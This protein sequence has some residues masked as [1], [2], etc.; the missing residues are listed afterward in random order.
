MQKLLFLGGSGFLG[1][2]LIRHFSDGYRTFAV[3]RSAQGVS[4][5]QAASNTI[6][7]V[8][9]EEAAEI[10][11][12][13]IFNLIVDYGRGGAP[14]ARVMQSNLVHPLQMLEVIEA[15]AVIN[16]STALPPIYS[17]Y[18]L[19]K[20]LLEQSLVHLEE[21]KRRSFFNIH[22]HNM[23]GPG[24]EV[25]ELIGFAGSKLLTDQ[26]VEVSEC[27]NSRDFIFV[28]DVV[29]ALSTISKNTD[30]LSTDAPIE[31]GSGQA[32]RLR[33]LVLMLKN[34]T[35][36]TSDLCFGA[37]PGNAFEPDV[38]VANIGALSQLGWAPRHSLREGLQVTLDALAT[39][40]RKAAQPN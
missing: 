2:H 11:F 13:R 36:S 22:L 26:P 31:I 8:T 9:A 21:K 17:Y 3:P 1:Q 4:K 39:K 12:D 25:S 34:L 33:D 10:R 35:G 27:A 23:Y 29:S 16:V 37:R 38:L 40:R 30:R 32:T 5:L 20:K 6:E 28:D 7:I 24:G 14:L 15:E 18:A 19:S